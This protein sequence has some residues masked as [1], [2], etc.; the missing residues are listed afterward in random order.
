[1]KVF[2]MAGIMLMLASVNVQASTI[3]LKDGRTITGDIIQQDKTKVVVKEGDV[4]LTYY[5]DEIA[6]IKEKSLN[7]KGD[8]GIEAENEKLVEQ[9][10]D[11]TPTSEIVDDWVKNFIKPD[12]QQVVLSA[13]NE[14]QNMQALIKVRK[15]ILMRVFSLADLKATI[16][17][18]S[19][20]EGKEHL[21]D[22]RKMRNQMAAEFIPIMRATAEKAKKT[23]KEAK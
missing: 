20:P 8:A 9:F 2:I 14:V 1:M 12:Q 21:K 6:S 7:V 10:M 13:E 17:F 22:M 3:T 18:Y 15:Q 23:A 16:S 19:S 11:Y 4:S 5:K